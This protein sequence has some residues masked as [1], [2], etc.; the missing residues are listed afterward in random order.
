[1]NLH[2]SHPTKFDSHVLPVGDAACG[3]LK[4]DCRSNYNQNAGLEMTFRYRSV[5]QIELDVSNPTIRTILNP[6]QSEIFKSDPK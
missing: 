6:N 1:M 2:P 4:V 3:N 5:H